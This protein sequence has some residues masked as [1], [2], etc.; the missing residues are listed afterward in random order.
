M[1][2][3]APEPR[4]RSSFVTGAPALH[5]LRGL[6]ELVSLGREV[7]ASIPDARERRREPLVLR[8]D[9]SDQPDA[10][11]RPSSRGRRRSHPGR[12]FTAGP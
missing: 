2:R 3:T 6:G 8:V 9:V 4:I 11:E 5:D 12:P 1:Q 10:R 7:D